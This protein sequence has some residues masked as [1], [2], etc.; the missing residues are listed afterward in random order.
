MFRASLRVLN[1]DL[2]PTPKEN[3]MQH[4]TLPA[5]AVEL[6]YPALR[7]AVREV[8]AGAKGWFYPGRTARL[9]RFVLPTDNHELINT[10]FEELWSLA[11]AGY[12][13]QGLLIGKLDKDRIPE[14]QRSYEQVFGR[15]SFAEQVRHI[16]RD[17]R[18]AFYS[19]TVLVRGH[20]DWCGPDF[21]WCNK[22]YP[23]TWVENFLLYRPENA[24]FEAIEIGLCGFYGHFRRAKPVIGTRS[25]FFEMLG[26]LFRKRVSLAAQSHL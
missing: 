5:D 13:C 24:V 2:L 26:K 9:A 15:G 10:V 21:A 22:R 8:G 23:R 16:R 6:T 7:M 25:T 11:K 20:F 4:F 19:A 14:L 12:T 1:Q 3:P 18:K 17:T